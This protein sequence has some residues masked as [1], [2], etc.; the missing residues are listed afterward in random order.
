MQR[1]RVDVREEAARLN[2][3]DKDDSSPPL[4]GL[5]LAGGE[6]RRM[7]QDKGNL[8]MFADP[9]AIV[10][11]RMLDRACGR[12]FVSVRPGQ[13]D[14]EPYRDLPHIVDDHRDATGPVAGL[15]AAWK[16]YED[17]AWLLLAADMP[18]VDEAMFH[19]LIESR[20]GAA[21]ATSFRHPDGRPEPLCTIWEPRADAVL[22]QR[23]RAGERSL[24][25]L[26]EVSAVRWV[27]PRDAS[28][29]ASVNTPEE[30]ER[31]RAMLSGK[32]AVSN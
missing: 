10:A 12:A 1:P 29:L 9:Q 16:R 25:G 15:L 23:E 19:A 30:L 6:S 13:A 27:E 31:A 4:W 28:R 5:V 20:D 32:H 22:R 3:F 21:L 24:S 26:L 8:A 2:S 14:I 7:G 17:V 18:F 11:W